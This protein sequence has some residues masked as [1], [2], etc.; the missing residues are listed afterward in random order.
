M[1]VQEFGSFPYLYRIELPEFREHDASITAYAVEQFKEKL[2]PA[3]GNNVELDKTPELE[4]LWNAFFG[5]CN[6]Y[7]VNLQQIENHPR[8]GAV[9]TYVQ[10]KEDFSDVWHNHIATASINGVYYPSVPDPT[11]TLSV[12]AI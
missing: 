2:D 10:N 5:V 9:W 8:H 1:L 4:R 3:F 6:K 11:G 7:F 12:I